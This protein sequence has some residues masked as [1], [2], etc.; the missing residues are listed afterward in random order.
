MKRMLFAL[1]VLAATAGPTLGAADDFE[2]DLSQWGW[3]YNGPYSAVIGDLE[4]NGILE[5]SA[6]FPP[7]PTA[8]ATFVGGYVGESNLDTFVSAEVNVGTFNGTTGNDQ[9]LVARL[10]MGAGLS[11]YA[12]NYDPYFHKIELVAIEGT[13]EGVG[14]TSLIGEGMT[15]PENYGELGQTLLLKL[16]VLDVGEN[17]LLVGQAWDG[18]NL[19]GEVQKLVLEGGDI[20][21][22]GSG[23][24]GVYAALNENESDEGPF[25]YP[26]PLHTGFDNFVSRDALA[27]DV[28]LD[29]RVTLG[30]L[31]IVASYYGSS[32]M[33]WS[34][35]DFSGDGAVTLG[36]L[37]ICASNYGSSVPGIGEIPEPTTI[38]LLALG[39]AGLLKRRRS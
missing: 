14:F 26:N 4:G 38:A 2:G 5:L 32:G 11:A 25:P 39:G 17:V 16:Q 33:S 19:L 29:G 28:N 10:T 22:L 30:D 3:L 1:A 20:P 27:G 7:G 35:G 18:E 21:V 31:T 15:T 9:G 37:T 8:G 36:D 23:V 6:P 13:A 24:S 12:L 34:K